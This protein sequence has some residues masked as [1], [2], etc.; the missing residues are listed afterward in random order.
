MKD[1]TSYTIRLPAD[2][3]RKTKILAAIDGVSVNQFFI[4]LFL[5]EVESRHAQLPT[6]L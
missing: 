4:S 1:E 2:L 3:Y 6:E 5:R